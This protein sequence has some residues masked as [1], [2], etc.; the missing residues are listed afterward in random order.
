[1]AYMVPTVRRT[2][3]RIDEMYLTGVES[4]RV[5]GGRV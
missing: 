4:E 2:V 3:R 5:I 1:M